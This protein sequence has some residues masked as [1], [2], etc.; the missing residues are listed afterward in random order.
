MKEKRKVE[1][2]GALE[3][4]LAGNWGSGEM[5]RLD[6]KDRAWDQLTEKAVFTAAGFA[7]LC[8]F[9]KGKHLRWC[10]IYFVQYSPFLQCEV[11]FSVTLQ[12]KMD[13]NFC[14]TRVICETSRDQLA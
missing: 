3:I 5:P 14:L 2:L 1:M 8:M 10:Y 7:R 9:E 12:M 4:P 13:F 11:W 6:R